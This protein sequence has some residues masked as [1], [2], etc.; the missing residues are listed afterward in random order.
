[1]NNL[2]DIKSKYEQKTPFAVPENYFS[3]FSENIMAK[4]PEK[5]QKPVTKITLWKRV[6]PVIYL[7]AMFA[8]AIWSVN[9][10]LVK[11]PT[12]VTHVAEKTT[13]EDAESV[14]ITM[15]VDDYSVY[16]Y[17]NEEN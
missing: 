13:T 3:Q 5:E 12:T 6:K 7:A 9:L 14:S 4:L 10:F 8:A 1:M 17:M 16:E 2:D 15:A 11:S